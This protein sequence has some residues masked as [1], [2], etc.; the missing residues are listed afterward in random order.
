MQSRRAVKSAKASGD[1]EA[2]RAARTAVNQAKIALGERGPTWWD[3]DVDYN[4]CLIENSP[5]VDWWRN[6]SIAT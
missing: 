1:A 3:D 2:F 5:Y 4:Q 6:R